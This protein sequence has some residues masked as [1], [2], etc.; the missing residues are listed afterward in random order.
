M[1]AVPLQADLAVTLVSFA[2]VEFAF[3]GGAYRAER[4]YGGWSL[5]A[6]Y[7]AT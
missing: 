4:G 7:V 3:R 1:S 6:A 5:P 2:V